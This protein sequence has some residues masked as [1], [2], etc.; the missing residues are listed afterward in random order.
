MSGARHHWLPR[1]DALLREFY[2]VAPTE[3]LVDELG[4]SLRSV[5]ERAR[6]LGLKKSP[7]FYAADWSGRIRR[8]RSDPRMLATQFRKGH[9]PA[10]KGMRRPG[11]APGRMAETQFKPG[12]RRGMAAHNYRPIGSLRINHDGILQRKLTDDPALVPARRWRA[13]HEQVWIAAFGALPP[14]HIVVF[15]PGMHTT[16]EAEITPDR[17]E[18]ISQVENMRRNS[19]HSR[20]PKAVAELIQLRGALKRKIHNRMRRHEEQDERCA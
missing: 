20:Y 4:L 8:G 2:P 5:Y 3:L 7:A 17:L 12:E 19:V 14:G 9:V 15:R 6:G 11:W 13:V 1:E 18:C 16:V 10:N